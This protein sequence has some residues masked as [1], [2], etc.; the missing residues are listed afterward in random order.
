MME[1]VPCPWRPRTDK[2]RQLLEAQAEAVTLV[3][4]VG[5]GFRV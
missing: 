2:E 5:L 4:K 3:Q 1:V